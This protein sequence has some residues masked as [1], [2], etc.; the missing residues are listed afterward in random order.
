[1]IDVI[2]KMLKG[3]TFKIPGV[4]F[5]LLV[6]FTACSQREETDTLVGK[7]SKN[8]EKSQHN[9]IDAK[10][11]LIEARGGVY[12]RIF[13]ENPIKGNIISL[14]VSGLDKSAVRYIWYV[15]GSE[16][17]DMNSSVLE[18]DEIEKGDQIMAEAVSGGVTYSS[19]TVTVQN[20]PPYIR[21]AW[22]LPKYPVRDSTLKAE[23][24]VFDA[25]GDKVQIGYEW[26]LNGELVQ[27]GGTASYKGEFSRGDTIRVRFVPDDEEAY[28]APVYR[29]ITIKNSPPVVKNLLSGSVIEGDMYY[30]SVDASDPDGDELS[31][32]LEGAPVNMSIDE[33]TGKISWEIPGREERHEVVVRVVDSKGAESILTI[34]FVSNKK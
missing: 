32:S 21:S 11:N 31:Y 1:M 30:A 12:L 20:T 5:L 18:Y 34:P 28:G 22:I 24:E 23:A 27:D 29:E 15:N 26:Y 16:I 9:T 14:K 25:D 33:H 6:L 4:V 10:N 8:L 2:I 3:N 13:P 19:E 17:P 7:A